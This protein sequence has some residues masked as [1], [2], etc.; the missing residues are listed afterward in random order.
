METLRFGSTGAAVE[1]LQ[2]ALTRAGF[3]K[4]EITGIFDQSTKNAVMDFQRSINIGVDGIVGIKTWQGLM[5]YIKG[6]VR[7]TIRSG[8]T[9]WSLAQKYNTTVRAISIANPSL[10]PLRLAIGSQVVI[11][12]GF[13]LVPTNI[14]LSY[15]LMQQFI[16][17]LVAR[18]PFIKKGS[19][20]KSV[21]GKDLTLLQIGN[22]RTQVFY[23]ASHHANEWI[24]SLVLLKFLEDYARAYG[25]GGRIFDMS[26]VALYSTTSL[27]IVPMV[28]PDGVDLVVGAIPKDSEY[29]TNA[30]RLSRNY[31]DIPFPNGWKANIKGIDLNVNYPAEWEQAKRVKAD[32]GFTSPGPREFVGPS[33]LSEPETRAIYEFTLNNDFVLILAYHTQGEVIYWKFLD[34]E[35]RLSRKIGEKFSQASGYPLETAPYAS[36]FAGYKDWFIQ[37]YNRPGYTVEVGRGVSPLP[38][39]Q[40]NKIYNDNLGILT[41]GLSESLLL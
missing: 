27:S 19:V 26:A 32:L 36:S 34:F 1:L 2:L 21:M 38:L 9:F 11:P 23:N 15:S 30:L 12:L 7:H 16:D 28:N 25:S 24:T 39:S 31:P 29:Y 18:Y 33:P 10:D 22:G 37:N 4:S 14:K 13:D 3:Y 5:P 35:P 20:G 41:L 6:Y 8:D 17:G 40:F